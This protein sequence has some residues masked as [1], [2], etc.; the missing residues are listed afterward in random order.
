MIVTVPLSVFLLRHI[1][2]RWALIIGLSAFATA[3]LLGTQLTHDWRGAI[4]FRS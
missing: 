3:N 2:P 1:D 4:L